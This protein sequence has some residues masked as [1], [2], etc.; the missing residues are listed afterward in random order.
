VLTYGGYITP[1]QNGAHSIGATFDWVDAEAL[2]TDPPV[3]DA[4]HQR[5]FDELARVLPDLMSGG[6]QRILSGRA[7]LRCT[8]PDHLALAG[9]VPDYDGFMRDFAELRHGHPWARYSSAAYQPGLYTLTGLG[10]RGLVAGPLA[11]EL[12]ASQIAGEPWPVERDLG[13]ALHAGRFLVRGLK[14]GA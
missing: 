7:G 13:T 1:A 4:D 3:H 11:A 9:P 2:R 5:N 10:A 6:D 14:R 12:V 8:T